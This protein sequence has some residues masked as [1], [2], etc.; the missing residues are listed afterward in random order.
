MGVAMIDMMCM[1]SCYD[2]ASPKTQNGNV[3]VHP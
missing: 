2:T 1:L 3:I